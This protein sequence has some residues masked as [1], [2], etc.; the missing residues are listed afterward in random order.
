MSMVLVPYTVSPY[1]LLVKI[2]IC[3]EYCKFH[4]GKHESGPDAMNFSALTQEQFSI[5]NLVY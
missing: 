2:K 3:I 4:F 5:W 1:L